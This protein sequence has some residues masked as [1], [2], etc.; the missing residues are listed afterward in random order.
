[1]RLGQALRQP[2]ANS[3]QGKTEMLGLDPFHDCHVIRGV[4]PHVVVM[5]EK[6][7]RADHRNRG[8]D[9]GGPCRFQDAP[10]TLKLDD[11]QNQEQNRKHFVLQHFGVVRK[12]VV[13]A[14]YANRPEL[15]VAPNQDEETGKQK[16]KWPDD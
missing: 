13:P 12:A 2:D 3:G 1:M 11:T 9:P 6:H 7:C 10:S 5:E 14:L 8:K 16:A 4:H 15:R